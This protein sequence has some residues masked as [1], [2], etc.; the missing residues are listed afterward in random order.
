MLGIIDFLI[1]AG[2][3]VK[4]VIVVTIFFTHLK[5]G[6]FSYVKQSVHTRKFLWQG[7]GDQE[8]E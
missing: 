3:D 2:F 6:S 1:I 5:R 4:I 7:E 8:A